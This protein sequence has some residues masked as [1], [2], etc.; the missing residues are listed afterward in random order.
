MQTFQKCLSNLIANFFYS[1]LCWFFSTTIVGGL[2]A[3]IY[4][5]WRYVQIT[6][7]STVYFI[8][9]SVAQC[10]VSEYSMTLK[11]WAADVYYASL[12]LDGRQVAQCDKS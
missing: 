11:D 7:N 2:S 3:F 9:T 10:L 12:E 8:Q 6:I 5:V 4:N 1:L